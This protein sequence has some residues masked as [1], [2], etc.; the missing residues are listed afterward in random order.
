[1]LV[2]MVTQNVFYSNEQIMDDSEDAY[3]MYSANWLD[4]FIVVVSIVD[5]LSDY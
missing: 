3:F 2:K 1:M 5:W 4:F